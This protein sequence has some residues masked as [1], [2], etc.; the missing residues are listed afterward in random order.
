MSSPFAVTARINLARYLIPRQRI[1]FYMHSYPYDREE[2][3]EWLGAAL[4]FLGGKRFSSPTIFNEDAG[5]TR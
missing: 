4:H 3:F 5:E 1:N 2:L